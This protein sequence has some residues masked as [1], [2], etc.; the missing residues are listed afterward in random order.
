M[1]AQI[2]PATCPRVVCRAHLAD[3]K[4]VHGPLCLEKRCLHFQEM[5]FNLSTRKTMFLRSA[6]S[7]SP[8]GR[9]LLELTPL[10]FH[11]ASGLQS[12]WLQKLW[13]ALD[14]ASPT[15]KKGSTCAETC[16]ACL[17]NI[18]RV[19]CSPNLGSS[20]R[21]H[22]ISSRLQ[23]VIGFFWVPKGPLFFSRSPELPLMIY[24]S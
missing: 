18:N 2:Q 23:K 10:T 11:L 12:T 6:N 15:T 16:W 17:S 24:T 8:L 5:Q 21:I 13:D 22:L 3:R 9:F 19:L 1:I 20:K 14:S 4:V 7:G